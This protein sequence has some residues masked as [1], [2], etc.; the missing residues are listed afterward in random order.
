MEAK[1]KDQ[2][3]CEKKLLAPER[4]ATEHTDDLTDAQER[5]TQR[6]ANMSQAMCVCGGS[7]SF[8]L[9]LP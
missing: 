3:C 9:L 6:L 5:S 7:F 4:N 8:L 1:Q 2:N